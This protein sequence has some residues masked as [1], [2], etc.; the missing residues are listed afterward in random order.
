VAIS[1]AEGGG[2]SINANINVVPMIDIM[3]VLLIIFMIVTPVISA[4]FTATM[5]IGANVT[6]QAE[7]D[8]EVTL[9][10]DNQGEYFVNGVGRTA[11]DAEVELRSL[12]ANRDK[13]KLLYFKADAGLPYEVVQQG[14]EM[15]RRAGARVLV[16]IIDRRGGLAGEEE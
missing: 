7:E 1:T 6:P 11:A 9:G 15:G 2:S 4:G 12:Y 16:A 5:P 14:V 10:I 3:L 13:D 8:D